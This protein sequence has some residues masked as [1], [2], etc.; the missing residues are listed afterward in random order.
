MFENNSQ[1]IDDQRPITQQEY[2]PDQ[3]PTSIGGGIIQQSKAD[4]EL[5]KWQLEDADVVADI[6]MFLRGRHVNEKGVWEQI[7]EP[8]MNEK[9]IGEILMELRAFTSK[10]FKLS[11]YTRQE[12]LKEMKILD[13][14]LRFGIVQNWPSWGIKNE[15][16]ATRVKETILRMVNSTMNRACDAG[17][18]R[19]LGV[20]MRRVETITNQPPVRK[21]GSFF[22]G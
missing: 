12:I 20:V 1:N 11:N 22:G 19:H 10:G 14:N 3:Y 8:L 18:R 16:S 7:T 4:A 15:T 2:Y 17:E 21:I 6:E 5:T 9:G 13:D